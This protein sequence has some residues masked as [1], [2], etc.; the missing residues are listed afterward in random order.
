MKPIRIC[1]ISLVGFLLLLS[2]Y[3]FQRQSATDS[4]RVRENYVKSEYMVPMRDGVKLFTIVYA[5]KNT[6]Q[7][8]P[9]LITRTAYG[10]AP[11]G[12]ENYRDTMDPTTISLKRAT[13]SF[14]RTCAGAGCRKAPSWICAR[15]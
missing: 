8:Y 4:Y 13:S 9:F 5:P 1:L 11:Y 3:A 12:P 6:S 15:T 10:I 7:K 2:I 14:I